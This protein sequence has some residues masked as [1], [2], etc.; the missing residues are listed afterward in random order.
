MQIRLEAEVRRLQE[1]TGGRVTTN[2]L[3]AQRTQVLS[4]TEGRVSLQCFCLSHFHSF[5]IV[6]LVGLLLAAHPYQHAP[7][8]AD[9]TEVLGPHWGIF[10]MGMSFRASVTPE[11]Y[12]HSAGG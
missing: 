4:N 9:A 11:G 12:L 10:H 2:S 8:K 6:C 5:Y 3:S 7:G 1:N